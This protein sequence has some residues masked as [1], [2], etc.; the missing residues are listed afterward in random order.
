M[1]RLRNIL[2]L[3]WSGWEFHFDV[4]QKVLSQQESCFSFS[5]SVLAECFLDYVFYHYV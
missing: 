2:D 1:E 5:Y 3:S 4:K